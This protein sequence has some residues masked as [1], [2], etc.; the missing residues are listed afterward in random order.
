MK[1]TFKVAVDVKPRSELIVCSRICTDAHQV[2][3][4]V[5]VDNKRLFHFQIRSIGQE[6]TRD[7]GV[8]S[9]IPHK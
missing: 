3:Q 7:N 6:R 5:P 8:L 1:F 4:M 2:G 9:D